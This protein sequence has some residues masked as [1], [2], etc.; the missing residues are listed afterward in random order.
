MKRLKRNSSST[1]SPSSSET[2][3]HSM[4][5]FPPTFSFV[6]VFLEIGVVQ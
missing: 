2:I 6:F 1:T 5:S 4:T 3:P